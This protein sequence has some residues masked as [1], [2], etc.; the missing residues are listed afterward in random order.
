[1]SEKKTAEIKLRIE[2]SRKARYQQAAADEEIGLSEFI[3]KAAD[4][5][6]WAAQNQKIDGL[7]LV[8]NAISSLRD[9]G[10]GDSAAVARLE[11]LAADSNPSVATDEVPTKDRDSDWSGD[12]KPWGGSA[13]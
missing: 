5:R 8:D 13:A 9:I 1:M 3:V 12:W 7:S 2:P 6:M 10:A 4:D 11:Q